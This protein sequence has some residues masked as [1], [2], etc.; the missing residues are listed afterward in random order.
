M[1]DLRRKKGA[2]I[3]QCTITEEEKLGQSLTVRLGKIKE[4]EYMLELF[5]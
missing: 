2:K 1:S 5:N 3:A 4:N